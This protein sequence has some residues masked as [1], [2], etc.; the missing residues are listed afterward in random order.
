MNLRDEIVGFLFLATGPNR[1]GWMMIFWLHR[2]DFKEY[3]SP[4]KI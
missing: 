4:E 1:T 3:L 2:A